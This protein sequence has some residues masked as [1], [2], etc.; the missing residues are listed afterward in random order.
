MVKKKQT[1]TT[2][3]ELFE[4]YFWVI[5]NFVPGIRLIV[6]LSEL[7]RPF[8]PLDFFPAYPA[9]E[10]VSV[11]LNEVTVDI[12]SYGSYEMLHHIT[13]VP[14]FIIDTVERE[15]MRYAKFDFLRR[16]SNIPN[17]L[18]VVVLYPNEACVALSMRKLQTIINMSGEFPKLYLKDRGIC[19]EMDIKNLREFLDIDKDE[20]ATSPNWYLEKMDNFFA[21]Q[22]IHGKPKE[23]ID[24]KKIASKDSCAIQWEYNKEKRTVSCNGGKP[25]KLQ[26]RLFNL[27]HY[28]YTHAGKKIDLGTLLRVGWKHKEELPNYKRTIQ[29][30]INDLRSALIP[31]GLSKE[32]LDLIIKDIKKGRE[33]TNIKFNKEIAL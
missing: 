33:I 26:T 31:T 18:D 28:L 11:P 3:S 4:S 8:S 27:W 16:G 25:V 12:N 1:P 17:S 14:K 7:E 22:I 5:R 15:G 19:S 21:D 2:N 29:E 23:A 9:Y 10:R 32:K 30:G 20:N 13:T 6:L 24:Q